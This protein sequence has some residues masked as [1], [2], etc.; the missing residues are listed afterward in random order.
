MPPRVESRRDARGFPYY[1]IGFRRSETDP[2]AETDLAAMEEHR[3][4]VTPLSLDLTDEPARQRLAG[5]FE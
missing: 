4:S 5:V 2:A 3:I 1:W